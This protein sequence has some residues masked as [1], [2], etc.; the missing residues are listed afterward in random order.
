MVSARSA[1]RCR[2][3]LRLIVFDEPYWLSLSPNPIGQLLV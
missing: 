1:T 2:A 3:V